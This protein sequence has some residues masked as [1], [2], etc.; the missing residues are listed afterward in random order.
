MPRTSSDKFG[1]LVFSI[2]GACCL[3]YPKGPGE[4]AM[5]KNAELFD[6]LVRKLGF[7]QVCRQRPNN[8]L[9]STQVTSFFRGFISPLRFRRKI[10]V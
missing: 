1:A 2:S 10:F 9:P 8:I 3:D 6:H 4:E 5:Q 7:D